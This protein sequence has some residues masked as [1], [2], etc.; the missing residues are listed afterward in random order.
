L[1][2]ALLMR[3]AAWNCA[4]G[5]TCTVDEP[6]AWT[7]RAVIVCF[8]VR[9]S[10]P[11]VLLLQLLLRLDRVLL[12]LRG[13]QECRL[14]FVGVASHST[15]CVRWT[16]SS[17]THLQSSI[18]GDCGLSHCMPDSTPTQTSGGK[19]SPA[20]RK[21]RDQKFEQACILCCIC[22]ERGNTNMMEI[23]CPTSHSCARNSGCWQARCRG[24]GARGCASVALSLILCVC[25]VCFQMLD[26]TTQSLF[27]STG[28]E[29]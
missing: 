13:A 24:Q 10:G 5:W 16:A 18:D 2:F 11:T 26:A 9:S 8:L 28:K 21:H 17:P 3:L 20:T 7:P 27:V 22:L 25:T 4:A 12:R 23:R 14:V 1:P 15:C 6:C 19:L 29:E